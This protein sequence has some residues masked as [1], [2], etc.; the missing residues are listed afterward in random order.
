MADLTADLGKLTATIMH[1][2]YDGSD[3]G[4]APGVGAAAA[5]GGAEAAGG[6]QYGGGMG[7]G[8]DTPSIGGGRGGSKDVW[9]GATPVTSLD[10]REIVGTGDDGVTS[11]GVVSD[12]AGTDAG[13]EDGEV[14]LVELRLWPPVEVEAVAA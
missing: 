13:E 11:T 5:G 10:W 3:Q 8:V 4:R 1:T 14:E 9:A 2:P 7:S 6:E 12:T